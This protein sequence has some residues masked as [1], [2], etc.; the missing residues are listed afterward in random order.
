MYPCHPG[1]AREA[2]PLHRTAVTSRGLP[3]CLTEPRPRSRLSVSLPLLPLLHL[4]GLAC[5]CYFNLRLFS[6]FQDPPTEFENHVGT[7]GPLPAFGGG[8]VPSRLG[9]ALFYTVEPPK[10]NQRRLH[11]Q[12]LQDTNSKGRHACI[13][14]PKWCLVLT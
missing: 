13:P 3:S 4:L 5:S 12:R 10:G 7:N 9:S 14:G 2:V 1:M 11:P 6:V 8:A